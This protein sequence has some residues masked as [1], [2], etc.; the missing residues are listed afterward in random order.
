MNSLLRRTALDLFDV[1]AVKFGRFRLKLHETNPQAPLSPIY[2]DLRT[3]RSFPPILRDVAA[4]LGRMVIDLRPDFVADVPTAA[5]S[6]VGVIACFFNL[7]MLSPRIDRKTHGVQGQVEGAF[8]PGAAVVLVD[9]LI[10]RAQSKLEAVQVL[11]AHGL[12]VKD[13]V[14]LVDREQGGRAGL[15]EH[16]CELHAAFTLNEMLDLYA[17]EGRITLEQ[18]R[19]VLS[20]LSASGT[21]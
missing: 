19:E 7:P 15:L 5:S 3:A 14:V 16:G 21:Q 9:D 20:Y 4:V 6:I 10:T 12:I 13:V 2:I 8:D 17:R 11:R 18:Q 1:G